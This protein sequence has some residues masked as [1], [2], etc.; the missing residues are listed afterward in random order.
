[1]TST[2]GASAVTL[3]GS[4]GWMPTPARATSSLLLTAEDESILL[5]AGTGVA[6]LARDPE[7]LGPSGRLVVALSHFHIDHLVGLTYLPALASRLTVEIWAPGRMPLGDD[8]REILASIVGGPF[9]SVTLDGFVSRVVELTPGE[10]T[11]GSRTFE[12]RAQHRHPGGSVAFRLGDELAYCTDTAPDPDTV[13]FVRG[14][15]LLV[16]EAWS[17]TAPTTEH[18][19]A[20]SAAESAAS[21]DVGRLVLCHVNP[22]GDRPAELLA[23]ALPTFPDTQVGHD[24]LG[25][26]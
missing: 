21:A 20:R 12:V 25:L 1:M 2:V 8:S 4:G 7:L 17:P 22:L 3:L 6:A 11:I 16:H 26:R 10:N 14:V 23:A 18:S 5:D 19:S 13:P 15:D 24:G 9:L